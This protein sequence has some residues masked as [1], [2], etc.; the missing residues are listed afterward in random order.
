MIMNRI[1]KININ[2]YEIIISQFSYIHNYICNCSR[3]SNRILYYKLQV[4]MV[5]LVC[6]SNKNK[7]TNSIPA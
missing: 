6:N 7:Q 1:K 5:L 2:E 4:F 3:D